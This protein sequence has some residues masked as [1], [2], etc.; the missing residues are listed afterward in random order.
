MS[1]TLRP[2]GVL[3]DVLGL[4]DPA[5]IV[6]GLSFPPEHRQTMAVDTPPLFASNRDDPTVQDTISHTLQDAIRFTP[7]NTLVFFPSYAEASRYHERLTE[8][9]DIPCYLDQPGEDATGLRQQFVEESKA[10]LL[11]SLWGT[12]TEG[13]SFDGEDARSVIVVGVPYPRLDDRTEAIQAAYDRAFSDRDVADPGWR[14]AIE[15][16]TI[17][18]TRQALGR[19]IRSPDDIGTRILLDR[20]YTAGGAAELGDYSV[21]STLPEELRTEL[22][23]V[24]PDKLKFS[25]LNFYQRHDAYDGT[26]PRP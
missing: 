7:G 2:F 20:R 9:L 12:L 1:A 13:V 18:K 10:V 21:Y 19:V 4:T 5:T 8:Q 24:A 16:P 26:P 22:V 3:Q 14:Y 17:R 25:L 23:D 6:S 11:T 15:I